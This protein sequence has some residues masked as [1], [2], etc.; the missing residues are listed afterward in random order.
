MTCSCLV[1]CILDFIYKKIIYLFWALLIVDETLTTSI[2]IAFFFAALVD[3]GC[4]SD[5]SK[6]GRILFYLIILTLLIVWTVEIKSSNTKIKVYLYSFAIFVCCGFWVISQFFM[7]L[8]SKSCKGFI[9]LALAGGF[10]FFGIMCIN[11]M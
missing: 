8:N 6:C 10:G 2:A 5:K 11:D 3:L 1:N 9:Y 7:L 4:L